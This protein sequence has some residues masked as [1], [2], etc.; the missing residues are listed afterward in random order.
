MEHICQAITDGGYQY[1]KAVGHSKFKVDIA[2]INPYNSEEYLLGI[3]LDG[4]AYRQSTN[5]RDREV[6]QISVL[7]G[8]GWELHR[9]WTMD[10][11]DNRDKELLKLMQL[12]GEKKEAAYRIYKQHVNDS[13]KTFEM[14]AEASE[15][16]S[17]EP[18]EEPAK[19]LAETISDVAAAEEKPEVNRDLKSGTDEFTEKKPV[20]EM[21][22][23]QEP[24]PPVKQN[25]AAQNPVP[26][27]AYAKVA[28]GK[29]EPVESIVKAD[30]AATEYRVE[31]YSPA[32]V[33]VTDLS[34]ADYIKKENLT[35]IVDKMQR[36]VD[37]E[38]PIMYDRLVKKTLRAFHISRSS[39]QT[40]E[41]TDRA[42]KKVSVRMNKQAGVKFYWRK[43]QDPDQYRI[44][45]NEVNSSDKRAADEICQQELKNAVC[46]ALTEKGAL[47][48]DSL[49]KST[50]RIMGYAR[51]SPALVAAAEKGL[52]YGK[53]TGE[54]QQDEEKR[55]LLRN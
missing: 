17:E 43:D 26:E 48:K 29:N 44:C 18:M 41:A 24:V 28:S 2:V 40:L 55:Y 30:P 23:V 50:I 47:D 5:T 52:K 15:K 11:W 54:I 12:L 46:I 51:S 36:I 49:I 35:L 31:E 39:P 9:I 45:R 32:D 8:L 37:A 3:M 53:K 34:T 13:V 27:T 4:E 14:E 22:L 10:W 42:L 1:Q 33:E 38:A 25:F 16:P 19:E 21:N 20:D 6:A 7:N